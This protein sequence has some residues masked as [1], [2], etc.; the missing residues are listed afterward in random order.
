MAHR[1]LNV[2]RGTLFFTLLV[3]AV[4]LQLVPHAYTKQ[5]N[6]YFRRIFDPVLNIRPPRLTRMFRPAP[7]TDEFVPRNQYNDLLNAYTNTEGKLLEMQRRYET[8][9]GILGSTPRPGPGLVLARGTSAIS[10]FAHEIIINEGSSAGIKVGQL[11]MSNVQQPDLQDN[12][13]IIGSVTDV[14]ESVATVQLLTDTKHTI[15]VNVWREGLQKP[16]VEAPMVGNAKDGCK[17][18]MVSRQ[19]DIRVGDTVFASPER[20][21]LDTPIVVGLVSA[22]TNDENQPLLLDITVRPVFDRDSLTDVA[23]IVMNPRGNR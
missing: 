11:V 19:F 16:I 7:A 2:S 14:R 21:R 1:P 12:R 22:V 8:L 20:G 15:M 17:I 23:V 4:V 13:S 18:P 6:L 3:A 9:S 10:G 5:L